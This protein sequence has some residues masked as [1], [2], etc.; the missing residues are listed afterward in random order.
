MMLMCISLN[1]KL[2]YV[3]SLEVQE[4]KDLWRIKPRPGWGHVIS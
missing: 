3:T 2:P 4:F 1:G